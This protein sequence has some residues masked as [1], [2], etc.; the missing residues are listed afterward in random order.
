MLL[1]SSSLLLLLLLSDNPGPHL[2]FRPSG[3][4]LPRPLLHGRPLFFWKGPAP[5]VP[6]PFTFLD[7]PLPLPRDSTADPLPLPLVEGA[8]IP[9]ALLS[10]AG[11]SWSAAARASAL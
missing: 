11:A 10:L 6:L 9:A 4:P 1:L 7:N 8:A 3:L 5:P 2:R